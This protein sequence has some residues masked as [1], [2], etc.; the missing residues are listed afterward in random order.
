MMLGYISTLITASAITLIFPV[1]VYL[2][3]D[4]SIAPFFFDREEDDH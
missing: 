3:F 2:L 1:L 4:G